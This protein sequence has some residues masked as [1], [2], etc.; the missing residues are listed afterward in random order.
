L[1]LLIII[2]RQSRTT[3]N[4]VTAARFAEQLGGLGWQVERV[5]TGET[6][7]ADIDRTLRRW[8][9]D[10][11]LLLHAWRS[12][13]PWLLTTTA[14]AI[15]FAVLMT[16]TDLNRDLEDPEKAAVIHQVR[17]RTAAVIVQN[18]LVYEQLC[19]ASS[20][21]QDKLHLLPPGTRLGTEHFPLRER[22]QPAAGEVIL[23]HPASIRPVKGN[24]ELLRMSDRLLDLPAP[25]RLVFCGPAL[26][27]AY[28]DAFFTELAARPHACYLGEIPCD[29]MPS[30]M[31]QA[32]LILNNSDSEGVANALVEAAALGR[33]ILAR[34]IPGN[35][36]VVVPGVNGLL[37][38]GESGFRHQA[39][40][41]LT[42]AGLRR[43]LARPEPERY[44]AEAEGRRLAA[45]LAA[46]AGPHRQT[47]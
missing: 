38:D 28:A 1:R 30:A 4:H 45:I 9:P 16:G 11:A 37:Y 14:A 36:A 31:R 40:R 32:D 6:D 42:D 25:F 24:L 22:L 3:G 7:P 35:R 17:Q 12:G 10:A 41:L 27:S 47:T 18:H 33:P 34:D 5:E 44:T 2:P 46:I 21:W 29:A 26:D 20:P 15:P 43:H 39:G 19:R 13:R 8:R 23:L